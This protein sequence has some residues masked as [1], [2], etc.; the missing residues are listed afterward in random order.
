MVPS[1]TDLLQILGP[2]PP[3]ASFVSR[4]NIIDNQYYLAVQMHS[5]TSAVVHVP[6]GW[7]MTKM[8]ARTSQGV[9]VRTNVLSHLRQLSATAPD[10]QQLQQH[11]AWVATQSTNH[12]VKS[13]PREWGVYDIPFKCAY[14][15]CP[16]KGRFY[17]PMV[18]GRHLLVSL[19]GS[20]CCHFLGEAH[21]QT[22]GTSRQELYEQSVP[23]KPV[24]GAYVLRTNQLT[25]LS[26]DT[27]WGGNYTN[28]LVSKL[29]ARELVR[30]HSN[31]VV[32]DTNMQKALLEV[33]A[34]TLKSDKES[35]PWKKFFGSVHQLT[36]RSWVIATQSSLI[37]LAAMALSSEGL[38]MDDTSGFIKIA[39]DLL[40]LPGP[41]HPTVHV[42]I[43][44]APSPSGTTLLPCVIL[45]T[46]DTSNYMYNVILVD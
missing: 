2:L 11:V 27:L 44:G 46:V 12:C 20:G 34:R 9:T 24:G 32:F 17:V 21:S 7:L 39:A 14:T 28:K 42:W 13:L 26:S 31:A 8:F 29:T 23:L 1:E 38:K 15:Q 10:W 41:G 35:F 6:S 4:K 33:V 18:T 22:Y 43:L 19:Q 16:T 40:A 37:V 3:G 36:D 30:D 45:C 25:T 5:I